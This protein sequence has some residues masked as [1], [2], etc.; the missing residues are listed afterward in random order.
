MKI[1]LHKINPSTEDLFS[2]GEHLLEEGS[3]GVYYIGKNKYFVPKCSYQGT[4]L[5]HLPEECIYCD[6]ERVCEEEDFK[7]RDWSEHFEWCDYY[8]WW[9]VRFA[10]KII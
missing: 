10:E 9:V 6:Y 1:P 2:E 5:K 3:S 7:G 4:D 8:D